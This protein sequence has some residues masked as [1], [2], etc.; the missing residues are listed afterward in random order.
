M[1][2]E[3]I[4][5]VTIIVLDSLGIGALPDAGKYVNGEKTDEG[6]DTFGHIADSCPDLKIPELS[7]LGFG[8]IKGAAG[9][10]FA[11]ERPEGS[12]CRLAEVS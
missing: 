1:A 11:V 4:K 5:R 8:N 12:F 2:R 10:R 9:G 6:T 7:A 3:D